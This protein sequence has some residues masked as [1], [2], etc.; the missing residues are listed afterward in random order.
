[1][2]VRIVV[3]ASVSVC[4]AEFH[5]EGCCSRELAA[6]AFNNHNFMGSRSIL[7]DVSV[8]HF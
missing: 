4:K 8:W 6:V 1:M 5:T 2:C 7:P 3:L